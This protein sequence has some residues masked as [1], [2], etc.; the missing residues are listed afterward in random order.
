[1]ELLDILTLSG[2]AVAAFLSV[3][4]YFKTANRERPRLFSRITSKTI[5]ANQDLWASEGK[6]RNYFYAEMIIA[7]QSLLPNAL[8]GAKSFFYIDNHWKEGETLCHESFS[9][10]CNLPSMSTSPVR[11]NALIWVQG[12]PGADNQARSL[13]HESLPDPLYIRFELEPLS[14]K[15]VVMDCEYKRPPKS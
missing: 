4:V 10:P 5:K 9:F 12:A 1:M 15:P 2:S 13:S 8:L 14:G 7:N 3:I 6:F 11:I